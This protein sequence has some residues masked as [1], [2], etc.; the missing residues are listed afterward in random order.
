MIDP[1]SFLIQNSSQFVHVYAVHSI[2]VV[3]YGKVCKIFDIEKSANIL[4]AW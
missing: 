2:V 4:G 3:I 1:H